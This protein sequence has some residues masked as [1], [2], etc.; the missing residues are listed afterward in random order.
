M[1]ATPLLLKAFGEGDIASLRWVVLIYSLVSLAALVDFAVLARPRPPR[2][3]K[4]TEA[5]APGEEVSIDLRALGAL[6]GLHDFR[7]LCAVI[8]IDNGVF[9]GLIQLI[10]KI[11][12][13]KGIETGTAGNIRAVMVLAGVVGCLV[14][15]A[16]SDRIMRRKP[17]LVLAAVAAAPTLFLMGILRISA[18]IFVVGGLLGFFLLAPSPCSW[19]WRGRPPAPPSPGRPPAFFS[20]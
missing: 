15:P 7:L 1:A 4:R 16:V 17:F 5:E 11:L 18:Q 9:V 8:F 20:C 2:P 6:F 10:E 14:L 3:P 12:K 13:P 19:P